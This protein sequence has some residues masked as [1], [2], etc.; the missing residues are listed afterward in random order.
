MKE[1][2]QA[3]RADLKR[4]CDRELVRREVE[5]ATKAKRRPEFRIIQLDA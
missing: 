5:K 2:E 3:L 4:I 1:A